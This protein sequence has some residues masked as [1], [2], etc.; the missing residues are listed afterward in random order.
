MKKLTTE[1]GLEEYKVS[2]P[3]CLALLK[4]YKNNEI[5][6]T[7]KKLEFSGV[8]GRDVY[9]IS[10]PFFINGEE[11]IAG[12]VEARH[13][14]ADS[15]IV[16]F[17]EGKDRWSPIYGAPTFY[18][19]DC[20]V[21]RIGSEIIVEGVEAYP[22]PSAKYPENI[23]FQTVFYRGLDLSSL[24]KF[25]VGPE[26][27]KDIIITPLSN[28]HIG[29]F[30]RHLGA[31]N[32][33]G[34]IG[35]IEL[36]NLKEINPKNL[37]KARIIQNQFIPDEWGGAN[38]AHAFKNWVYV[39]GHIAYE[40]NQNAKHYYAMTF[41][42][43]INSHK[44]SEI[45]IIATRKNF[46]SGEAKTPEHEDIVFP[47]GLTWHRNNT[48]TLYVG[49]SDAESHSAEL[50]SKKIGIANKPISYIFK[51]VAKS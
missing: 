39:L 41:L 28:G 2:P 51:N 11:T 3:S 21:V 25:A 30:T 37:L 48:A 14:Q 19:E 13:A 24:K 36:L 32:G 15:E 12:R 49:L 50:S 43:Y 40:D 1:R 9:N 18:M 34:K 33:R 8:G 26:L 10:K 23:E 22:R 31:E 27:M 4:R 17:R 42:Y 16:F 38:D 45:K 6:P 20:R 35:F 7:G 44:A 47:S 29:V 5:F 46:L